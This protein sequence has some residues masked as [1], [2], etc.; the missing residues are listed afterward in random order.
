M[1][2]EELRATAQRRLALCAEVRQV[3]V[4][5]LQLP[6]DPEWITDD[7]PLFGRGIELDSV[8][9][10]EL[11]LC[12]DADFGVAITDDDIGAFGSVG[13]LALLIESARSAP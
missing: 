5:R 1:T 2:L 10:L 4:D 12:L 11:A 9:A 8:D 6:F 3:L 7:Q 13:R